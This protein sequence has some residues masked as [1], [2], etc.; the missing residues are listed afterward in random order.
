MQYPSGIYIYCST[1]IKH[2]LNTWSHARNRDTKMNKNVIF[3]VPIVYCSGSQIFVCKNPLRRL[4][5]IWILR[6]HSL[7]RNPRDSD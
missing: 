4:V 2:H 5:K 6:I 3:V 1:F 7:H